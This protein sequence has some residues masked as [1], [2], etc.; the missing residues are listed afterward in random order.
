MQ[1]SAKKYDWL[2]GLQCIG[3]IVSYKSDSYVKYDIFVVRRGN[4]ATNL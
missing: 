3:K 2:N 4:C 1:M